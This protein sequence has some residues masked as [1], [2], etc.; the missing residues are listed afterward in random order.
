MEDGQRDVI[1]GRLAAA[2]GDAQDATPAIGQALHVVLPSLDLPAPWAPSPARALT[3]WEGWPASR[4]LFY[5]DALV[6]GETGL[7]PRNPNATFVLGETWNSFSFSF[8]WG[9]DDPVRAVRT[10][11]TRFEVDRT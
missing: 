2:F 5:I 3:V 9:G 1:L 10:W 11:L 4:P 7:P 6:V 8:P